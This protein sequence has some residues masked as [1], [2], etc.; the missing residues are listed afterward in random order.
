MPPFKISKDG[1]ELRLSQR[2]ANGFCIMDSME[3][4]P[5]VT[6]VSLGRSADG[7]LEWIAFAQ[8]T[9]GFSNLSTGMDDK[10]GELLTL[11]LYPN[12]VTDGALHFSRTVSGTIYNAM[13]QGL[14]DLQDADRAD[15]GILVPGIYIFRTQEG[16]SIQFMVAVQ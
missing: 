9:P 3:F 14:M 13:G 1:E 15:V 11:T 7:G 5:Q 10:S 6:D 4:G 16:E 8:S 2:P 12:P